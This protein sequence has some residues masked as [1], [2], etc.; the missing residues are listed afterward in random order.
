MAGPNINIS[1][2]P[3]YLTG[4]EFGTVIQSTDVSGVP[5]AIVAGD[6]DVTG[7]ITG[8]VTGTATASA[9][10]TIV[11][12]TTNADMYP[13]WVT[14]NT[15]NLPLKT[16]SGALSFHPS[17]GVLT[18]TAFAGA[19]TGN[20]TGNVS[21][22]AATVTGAA[23]AAITSVGNLTGLT[24]ASDHIII[25]TAK[26]PSSAADTGTQGEIAWDAGFLYVCIATDTWVRV[27][28]AT[29]P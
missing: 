29:W 9:T 5:A 8:T 15:G 18:S 28:I 26:T 4:G 12:A 17:T 25:T 2:N 19:L 20:V 10:S 3:D 13:V 21:G 27:A 7:T 23:Q 1:S 6:L 14:A 11:N 22:T 16:T 24:I